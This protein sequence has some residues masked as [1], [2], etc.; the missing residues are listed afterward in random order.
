VTATAEGMGGEEGA[1]RHCPDMECAITGQ[2]CFIDMPCSYFVMTNPEANPLSGVDSV[3][4]SDTEAEL[5]DPGSELS[6]TF[7][8]ATFREAAASCSSETWCRHGNSQECANGMTCFAG[9]NADD[10]EC[11]INAIKK[12]EWEEG[13]AQSD[14]GGSAGGASSSNAPPSVAPQA[15]AAVLSPTD[16]RNQN[17][18]G[19]DW[20]DA[21]ANC[22]LRRFCPNGDD[23]CLGEGHACQ[24]YTT[25]HA[26]DMTFAP[27]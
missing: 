25:C 20:E 12:K 10:P 15:T 1:A 2:V 11:E 8:G 16:P 13:A 18:C 7:C 22:D 17:F 24:T 6:T 4:V 21:S 26:V 23:D 27:T 14:G 3:P 9:V 19:A 5:P